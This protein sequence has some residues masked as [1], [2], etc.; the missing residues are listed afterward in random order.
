[1]NKSSERGEPKN[2]TWFLRKECRDAEFGLGALLG[3][4]LGS[5]L[6]REK[7]EGGGKRRV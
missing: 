4:L 1:M 5:M 6:G 7:D 2:R 3:I